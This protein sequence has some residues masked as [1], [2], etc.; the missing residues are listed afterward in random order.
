MGDDRGVDVAGPG[1]H[2]ESLERRHAHRGVDA[3]AAVDGGDARPVAEVGHDQIELGERS[4]EDLRGACGDMS[5]RRAVEAVAADLELLVPVVRHGVAVS[6][7]RQGAMERGVEHG[8]VIDVGPV[9][10]R[11]L[12]PGEV[13]RQVQRCQ[14]HEA[15]Q[16]GQHIVVDPRRRGEHLAAVDD[17]VA[18][19]VDPHIAEL[20]DDVTDGGE[21]VG[22]L[23]D[24]AAPP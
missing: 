20:G 14:S 11:R 24:R 3:T 18:N 16:L 9:L 7:R 23:L 2:D 6:V 22:H 13:A 4:A 21:V 15:A 12:D 17:A 8:H 10:A 19:G 1:A 5:H